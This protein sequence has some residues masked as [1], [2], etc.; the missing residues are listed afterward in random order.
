LVKGDTAEPCTD[1]VWG[2]GGSGSR[3]STPER[4]SGLAMALPGSIAE[5]AEEVRSQSLSSRQF[6]Y[7]RLWEMMQ[8]MSRKAP[9]PRWLRDEVRF[10]YRQ[11]S[12][13]VGALREAGRW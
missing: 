12:R 4:D 6:L 10:P 1:R 8:S 13:Y 2:R 5:A 9:L 7:S 3:R 11:H